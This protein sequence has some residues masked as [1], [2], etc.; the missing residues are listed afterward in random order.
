[1]PADAAGAATPAPPLSPT[2]VVHRDAPLLSRAIAARL[3]ASLSDA[4]AERGEA[5]LVLTGGGI[6]TA[7]LAALRDTPAR[8]VID[9]SALDVYWGDERFVPAD[10]PDRNEG[11]ARAAL[12]DHVPLPPERVFAMAA[13]AAGLDAATAADD[14]AKVLAGRAAPGAA[15]PEFD[16]LLLGIGPD[17][18]IASIFPGSPTVDAPGIVLP[19]FGSPK[20]PPTRITL[21]YTAIRAARE[22]WVIAAG[23]EKADAVSRALS[24]EPPSAI[25]A[26]G[27][28]GTRRTLWLLDRAAAS[29]LP[30]HQRPARVPPGGAAPA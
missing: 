26:A 6:G 24:G 17:G 23:E 29:R 12:L 28:I 16:V 27:A 8:D 22:V 18:H 30:E 13:E 19:V 5:S 25:P 20:P 15:V 10:S 3:V 1:M 2:V 7:S 9:W 4:Q 14:Y 21:T 11:Q